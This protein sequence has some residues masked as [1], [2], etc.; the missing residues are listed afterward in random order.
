MITDSYGAVYQHLEY[1]PYG[2]TWIEEGGTQGG[3]IPGYKFT[4]KELDPE[5]GLYYYGA[6]YYDPVLSKWISADPILGKYLPTGNKEKDKNLSGIGGVYNPLNLGVYSYS[7]LNPVKFVDPDGKE[8]TIFIVKD[9]Y[10]GLVWIGS[11]SAV[12]IDNPKGTAT[13]YDPAGSVYN[14]TDEYG[15]PLR[16]ENDTFYG[17]AANESDYISAQEKLGSKVEVYRFA[18]TPEQEK[19]IAENIEKMGGAA[20][21][22]CTESVSGVIKGVGPFKDLKSI[23][24]PGK[25]GEELKN[26]QDNLS[27][28][29]INRVTG[30]TTGAGSNTNEGGSSQ[31]P[32]TGEG[33]G[34]TGQLVSEPTTGSSL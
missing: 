14:P 22:M 5:T 15:G 17:A 18:T 27:K 6:R 21:F 9:K 34:P 30:A 7:H 28:G 3:N 32:T 29:K 2:E 20:P 4:G 8:T 19:E 25:L 16:G 10:L 24:R 23:F 31:T 26:L 13:L 12:R 1:F 33:G 11:H